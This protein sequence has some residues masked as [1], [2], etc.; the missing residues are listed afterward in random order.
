[1]SESGVTLR[2]LVTFDDGDVVRAIEAQGAEDRRFAGLGDRVAGLAARVGADKLNGALDA[3]L[4]EV[5]ASAFTRLEKL[6][7]Q[8]EPGRLP[9]GQAAVVTLLDTKFTGACHPVL[10]LAVP[11]LEL[12]KLRFTLELE[13]AL[14][15]LAV[16]VE[17]G[18]IR[19]LAPG[20][21]SVLARLKYGKVKLKE[22]PARRVELP[23]VIRFEQGLAI[24]GFPAA[25]AAT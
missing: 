20:R 9:P 8:A 24:P 11:G 4:F 3:D 22:T 14:E 2:D 19:S 21:A 18:A 12:P 10:E 1:M 25:P 6:R 15:S 5:L 23:G 7:E 13:L 16:S 17:G